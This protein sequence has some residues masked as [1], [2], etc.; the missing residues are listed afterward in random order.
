MEDSA[1][2][3]G[4]RRNAVGAPAV[5]Q[6]KDSVIQVKDGVLQQDGSNEGPDLS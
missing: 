1:G 2:V 4:R 6:V 3:K 5:I